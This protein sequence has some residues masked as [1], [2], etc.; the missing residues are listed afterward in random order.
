VPNISGASP[1]CHQD[2][3]V[4]PAGSISGL[5]L[6][7]S[8]KPVPGFVSVRSLDD[9]K[10]SRFANWGGSSDLKPDGTFTVHFLPEGSY[11]IQFMSRTD[12][13]NPW[14]YPGTHAEA[15]AKTIFVQNGQHLRDLLFV[16]P[17]PSPTPSK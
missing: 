3:T 8:G 4:L 17:A 7:E 2:I 14:F 5:I 10:K 9:P 1:A 12:L 15:N 16:L 6:D 13:M 11:Q